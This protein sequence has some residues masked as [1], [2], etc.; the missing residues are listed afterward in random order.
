MP[1]SFPKRVV[2]V[3]DNSRSRKQ[4]KE[5]FEPAEKDGCFLVTCSTGQE[6]ISRLRELQPDLII[7]DLRMPDMNGPDTVE[8]LRKNSGYNNAPIIFVTSKLRVTMIDD[9]KTLGVLGILHKPFEVDK[10][11]GQV[12]ELWQVYRANIF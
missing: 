2:Y 7:L 9:Y 6:L 1:N 5:A 8:A 12:Q 3:D 11:R 10:L 4:M